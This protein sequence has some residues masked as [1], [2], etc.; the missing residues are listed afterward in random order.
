MLKSQELKTRLATLSDA[1]DLFEW[2]NDP[3]TM[4]MFFTQSALSWDSH[5]QWLEQA[6]RD[7]R[8]YLYVAEVKKLGMIGSCRFDLSESENKSFVSLVINP[9]FRGMGFGTQVLRSSL[10]AFSKMNRSLVMA[11]IKESNWKSQR[12]FTRAGFVYKG[13]SEGGV[14]LYG[15][16]SVQ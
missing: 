8:R 16:G 13:R 7:E 15:L 2:R 10:E 9:K 1:K 14:F 12:T 6:L 5:L 11:K 3:E 4:E